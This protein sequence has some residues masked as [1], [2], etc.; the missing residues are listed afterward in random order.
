MSN[1]QPSE[2]MTDRPARAIEHAIQRTRD[3][4]MQLDNIRHRLSEIRARLIDGDQAPK[5][6]AVKRGNIE[7]RNESGPELAQLHGNL[8]NCNGTIEM[9]LD[10]IVALESV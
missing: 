7:Q 8:D 6:E 4:A 9:I 3:N 5:L 2:A 1:G 10:N